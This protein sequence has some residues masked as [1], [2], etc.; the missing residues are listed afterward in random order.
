MTTINS[1]MGMKPAG[2][3]SMM[4]LPEDRALRNRVTA[5]QCPSCGLY[6]ANLSKVKGREGSLWCTGCGHTWALPPVPA[7][8]VPDVEAFA[9]AHADLHRVTPE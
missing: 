5:A 4:K 8:D 2:K 9:D 6:R 3:R 7:T 1:K